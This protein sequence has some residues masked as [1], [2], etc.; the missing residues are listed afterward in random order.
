MGR[1][2]VVGCDALHIDLERGLI[3]V[4]GETARVGDWLSLDGSTGE[5]IL[6]ELPT[7][8]SEVVQVALGKLDGGGSE[9]HRCFQRLL[10]WADQVRRLSVRANADKADDARVAVAF[11]AEG[12][13]LCRTE[14]MFFG[15]DRIAKM[16]AMILAKTPRERQQ[17]LKQLLT[18]QR[19]DFAQLFKAMG[20]LPVTVRTLD[21]PLH[22]FLPDAT[23]LKVELEVM[24]A[25]GKTKGRYKQRFA[26][27][28][29]LH[30]RVVELAEYNPMLGWR[31]CRLT[32][33]YPEIVEMQARAIFEA[34][35]QAL[36]R[37][38]DVRPEIMVPLVGHVEEL[39][40][41][42]E[43]IERTAEAVM[44]EKG[45]RVSYTIGTMIEVPRGALTSEAIAGQADF[46]SFGTNDLTQTTFGFSRDDA[47]KF[48]GHYVEERV[49]PR[50]PFVSIDR[51]GVGRLMRIAVEG[52]R[53][54]KQ[55]LK[56]GICGE[57]GGDPQSVGFCHD[58]GLDYVSCSPYRIP[59]ARL[60]A[61]QAVL[62]E[63]G[64]EQIIA[65]ARANRRAK[66]PPTY[67]GTARG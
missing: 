12:I 46:F 40:R 44:R 41:H 48:L 56:I 59:V 9:T 45:T 18:F 67:H 52:G 61:A 62:H 7:M 36:K 43:I 6:A 29:A 16:R 32:L 17:A 58:L 13:G 35:V 37:G 54:A 8:P 60:A 28:L 30:A 49:L 14:H 55:N 27:L 15:E 11:G 4:G 26:E 64:V 63:R 22:E 47:G 20:G 3:S 21:P 38:I 34:A 65:R 1:P 39:R 23:E 31:G 42:R 33:V 50:D 25:T 24:K 19:K 2:A 53:S 5:V 51:D 66:R 10:A 57:H